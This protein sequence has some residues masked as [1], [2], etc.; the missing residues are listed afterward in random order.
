MPVV[1]TQHKLN[2]PASPSLRAGRK[3]DDVDKACLLNLLHQEAVAMVE[4]LSGTASPTDSAIY[5]PKISLMEYANL[6]PAVMSD[7]AEFAKAVAADLGIPTV[8]RAWRLVVL[9]YHSEAAG[10]DWSNG[11]WAPDLRWECLSSSVL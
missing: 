7:A 1:L 3:L 11:R 5:Q 9:R 2:S 10:D 6:P 4:G 8:G